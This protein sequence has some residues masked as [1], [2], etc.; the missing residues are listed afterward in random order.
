MYSLVCVTL[1]YDGLS[2][3][4]PLP[5]TVQT[6]HCFGLTHLQPGVAVCTET[7]TNDINPKGMVHPGI[8]THCDEIST[9]WHWWYIYNT[10]FKQAVLYSKYNTIH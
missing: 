7:S 3:C 1:P 2:G 10:I 9:L 6:S 4:T 8:V 5:V